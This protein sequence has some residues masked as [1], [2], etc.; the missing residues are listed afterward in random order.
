MTSLHTIYPP[1]SYASIRSKALPNQSA[2]FSPGENTKYVSPSSSFSLNTN[3]TDII[4]SKAPCISVIAALIFGLDNRTRR[5]LEDVSLSPCCPFVVA[6]TISFRM[7][8][9]ELRT[10]VWSELEVTCIEKAC[11]NSGLRGVD[12]VVGSRGSF[13]LPGALVSPSPL[14]FEGAFD[15]SISPFVITTVAVRACPLVIAFASYGLYPRFSASSFS[16]CLIASTA[17]RVSSQSFVS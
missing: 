16:A 14:I 2:P 7:I 4:K 11:S 15:A 1:R 17:R 5:N 13:T 6:L 3:P 9:N 12:C 10:A 8:P